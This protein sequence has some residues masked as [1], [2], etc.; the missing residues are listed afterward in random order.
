MFLCA[1][2]I[3]GQWP[4]MSSWYPIIL[5]TLTYLCFVYIA[6]PRY[7]KNRPPYELKTFILFYNI[8]QVL[9]NAW[10]VKEHIRGGW[11]T[12]YG[13][14]CGKPDFDSPNVKIVCFH[15]I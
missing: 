14:K 9:A 13:V 15:V 11:F 5:V 1:D 7:M 3:T 8:I 2:P 4:M 12:K 6:G 10:I